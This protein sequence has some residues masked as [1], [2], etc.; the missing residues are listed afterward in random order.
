MR[1]RLGEETL[2]QAQHANDGMFLGSATYGFFLGLGFVVAGFKVKQR[3]L[4]FWGAG[5]SLASIASW[6]TMF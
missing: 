3:W 6:F 1:Y 5:L 4:T 2:R